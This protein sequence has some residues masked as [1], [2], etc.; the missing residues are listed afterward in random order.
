MKNWTKLDYFTF[1]IFGL[2][3]LFLAMGIPGQ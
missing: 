1:I 3:A 2:W